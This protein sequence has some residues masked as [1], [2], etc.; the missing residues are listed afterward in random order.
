MGVGAQRHTPAS[1]PPGKTQ[2]SLCRRLG[3]AQD[4][5]GLVWKISP[6]LGLDPWTVQPVASCYTD[7][8]ILDQLLEN[9]TLK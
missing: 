9:A 2:Y 3:G 6:P 8:A 5:S 4:H 7:F 1:L